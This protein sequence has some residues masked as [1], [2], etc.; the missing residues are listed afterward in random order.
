[1]GID[2][3]GVALEAVLS[4]SRTIVKTALI[5]VIIETLEMRGLHTPNDATCILSTVL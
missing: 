4:G 2:I 3:F 5:L 1:M